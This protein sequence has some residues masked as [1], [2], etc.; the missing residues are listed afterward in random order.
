MASACDEGM[1]LIDDQHAG[2]DELQKVSGYP[3]KM[4]CVCSEAGRSLEVSQ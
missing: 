2:V 1:G 4:R 3:T